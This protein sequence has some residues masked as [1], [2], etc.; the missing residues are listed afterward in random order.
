MAT[1]C[2]KAKSTEGKQVRDLMM[3][4]GTESAANSGKHSE[5]R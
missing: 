2:K 5:S 3:I 1:M 4:K